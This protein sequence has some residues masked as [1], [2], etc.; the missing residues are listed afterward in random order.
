[1]KAAGVETTS[2]AAAERQGVTGD[3]GHAKSGGCGNDEDGAILHREFPFSEFPI[4]FLGIP[5]FL[6]RNS[7]SSAPFG[8]G[9]SHKATKNS[10]AFLDLNQN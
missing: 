7:P 6:S 2:A 1:M 9:I 3:I 4:S 8:R 5:N 10:L